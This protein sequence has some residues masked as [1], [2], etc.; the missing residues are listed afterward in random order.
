[1][2]GTSSLLTQPW[3]C[4]HELPAATANALAASARWRLASDDTS[5]AENT[6]VSTAISATAAS[7]TPR[8]AS[9]RRI[10]RVLP[11]CPLPPV[12]GGTVA[13]GSVI[14][15]QAEPVAAAEHGHDDARVRR[16]LLDLAAQVL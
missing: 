10:P 9:A 8:N 3:F 16:I 2:I 6:A 14:A 1:M 5:T 4:C 15:R 12:T 7:A 13:A 11:R